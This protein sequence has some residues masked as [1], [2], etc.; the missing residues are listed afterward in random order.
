MEI[1]KKVLRELYPRGGNK[2]RIRITTTLPAEIDKRLRKVVVVGKGGEAA[3]LL[4]IALDVITTLLAARE[5]WN[6][7]KSAGHLA[8]LGE[9]LAGLTGNGPGVAAALRIMANAA[10]ETG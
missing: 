1:D 6:W 5:D 8:W 9:G 7:L 10:E 3:P 2:K 4:A